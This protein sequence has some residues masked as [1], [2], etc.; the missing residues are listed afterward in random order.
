MKMEPTIERPH[1]PRDPPP[2]KFLLL[3]NAQW[4]SR[5]RTLGL[6]VLC[7]A[8]LASFLPFFYLFFSFKFRHRHFASCARRRGEMEAGGGKGKRMDDP[9]RRRGFLRPP[10]LFIK[11]KYLKKREKW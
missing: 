8:A 9:I 7:D 5:T 1:S 4:P 2:S 11:R 3:E 10:W 6:A